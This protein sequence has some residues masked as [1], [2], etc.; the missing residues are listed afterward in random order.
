MT[1]ADNIAILASSNGLNMKNYR[2]RLRQVFISTVIFNHD[3]QTLSKE[4]HLN[5]VR[6]MFWRHKER[7]TK[8]KNHSVAKTKG[9]E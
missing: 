4:G 2:T 1:L 9:E 8:P 5:R 6:K 7:E 3:V